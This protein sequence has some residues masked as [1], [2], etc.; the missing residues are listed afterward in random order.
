M[1]G[2][3]WCSPLLN[4]HCPALPPIAD[5]SLLSKHAWHAWHSC[6]LRSL[7]LLSHGTLG[8]AVSSHCPVG[9]FSVGE[10]SWKH[11]ASRHWVTNPCLSRS[12]LKFM[13]HQKMS[14]TH[15]LVLDLCLECSTMSAV[16]CLLLCNQ[17]LQYCL[18][19]GRN[20]TNTWQIKESY[21]SNDTDLSSWPHMMTETS[22]S[23]KDT[24]QSWVWRNVTVI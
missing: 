4:P 19:H 14:F 18:A 1:C 3:H 17:H 22:P 20:S 12:S 13:G 10:L 2:H 9:Y 15:L 16:F 11:P 21:S 7:H 5:L 6:I 24:T 8:F 23:K